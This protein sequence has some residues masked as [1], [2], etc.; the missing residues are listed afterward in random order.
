MGPLSHLSNDER[1]CGLS[2]G[3]PGGS[4]FLGVGGL[5]ILWG[6]LHSRGARGGGFYCE[7]VYHPLGKNWPIVIFLLTTILVLESLGLV[8]LEE[9]ST[10]STSTYFAAQAPSVGSMMGICLAR[11]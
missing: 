8:P 11:L 5:I 7:G 10:D 1:S 9:E 2:E 4:M 6:L 3:G